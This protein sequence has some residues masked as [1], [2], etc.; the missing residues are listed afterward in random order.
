MKRLCFR[1]AFVST[2]QISQYAGQSATGQLGQKKDNMR[3][4]VT[5]PFGAKSVIVGTLHKG[6]LYRL[7]TVVLPETKRLEMVSV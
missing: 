1:I 3:V 7:V 4:M 2:S 5:V 6:A